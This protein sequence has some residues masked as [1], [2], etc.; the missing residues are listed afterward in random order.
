MLIILFSRGGWIALVITILNG[1]CINFITSKKI[2]LK[3]II[4]IIIFGVIFYL[5]INKINT[6]FNIIDKMIDRMN[7]LSYDNGAGRS[8]VWKYTIEYMKV[9]WGFKEVF[10][11]S[12]FGNYAFYFFGKVFESAHNF[13]VQ[14]CYESGLIGLIGL[15]TFFIIIIKEIITTSLKENYKYIIYLNVVIV[16]LISNT[17]DSHMYVTQTN[18]I[19]SF[20]F[21]IISNFI[22]NN[23]LLL[24]KDKSI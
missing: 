14:I 20:A 8:E 9:N 17:I 6:Q 11:G 10:F 1:L 16:F 4:K 23:K 24:S 5:V 3:S 15:C 19:Y 12:G 21:A 2:T 7:M 13:F 18:W 22:Y